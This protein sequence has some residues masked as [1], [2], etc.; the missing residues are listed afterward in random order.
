LNN[1]A[2]GFDQLEP[3]VK[4][5][6]R[7]TGTKLSSVVETRG[8]HKVLARS[9]RFEEAI[10][11][12]AVM[13]VWEKQIAE[14]KLRAGGRP[15]LATRPLDEQFVIASLVYNSGV[16]FEE[17]TITRIRALDTGDYLYASSE[18]SKTRREP[19]PVLA[20]RGSLALLLAG[21]D[22][23]A[24]PTSWSGAYHVLQRYG[25]YV[26]LARFTD[27]FDDQGRFRGP[28]DAAVRPRSPATNAAPSSPGPPARSTRRPR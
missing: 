15:S 27:A 10:A 11:G 24:Q 17:Q 26:A 18:R 5:V 12:T 13:W 16:L 21:A 7:A 1:I 22:Y 20:P 28:D 6:D 3:L 25:A 9:F 14:R 19:L 4:K 2:S 23:P 8:G